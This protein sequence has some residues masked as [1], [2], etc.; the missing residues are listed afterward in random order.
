MKDTHTHTKPTKTNTQKTNKKPTKKKKKNT[1][2][3]NTYKKQ[4][5]SHK[6]VSSG[7]THCQLKRKGIL[8]LLQ[9]ASVKTIKLVK[10]N[11]LSLNMVFP[12]LNN[13]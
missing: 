10:N 11:L 2:N 8:P 13:F 9:A 3:K 6:T 4:Q 1:Q 12:I 7:H 5:K